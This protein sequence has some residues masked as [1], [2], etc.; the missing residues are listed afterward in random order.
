MP[1]VLVIDDDRSV[2]HVVQKIFA[3]PDFRVV[4]AKTAGEGVELLP[5]CQ[6]DVVILDIMLPDRSGLE[7]FQEVHRHDSKLPVIF[8]T[9]G[10]TSET[11][12]EAMKLGA[13]DY[14]VKP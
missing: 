3:D 2:L 11:A 10:G 12:I 6:P 7:T 1:T 5:G 13:Y 14:L 8:I 4:T 9:A